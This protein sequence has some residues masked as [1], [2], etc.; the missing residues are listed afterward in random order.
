MIAF[1]S[2]CQK[3]VRGT[4]PI[5]DCG[6]AIRETSVYPFFACQTCGVVCVATT[7]NISRALCDQHINEVKSGV[8]ESPVT[9]H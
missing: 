9:N 2:Y 7:G 1:C 4:C 8:H 5:P 6:G 3:F